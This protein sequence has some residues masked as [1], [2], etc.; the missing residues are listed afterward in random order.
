MIINIIQ[1]K[2]EKRDY[3][4]IWTEVIAPE[5]S[6]NKKYLVSA[7]KLR[8]KDLLPCWKYKSKMVKFFMQH[9]Q[10]GLITYLANS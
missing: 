7:Q 5:R 10:N 3:W 1:V 4:L 9:I 8:F 2:F 6:E